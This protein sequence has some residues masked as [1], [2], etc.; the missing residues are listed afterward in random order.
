MPGLSGLRINQAGAGDGD[1]VPSVHSPCARLTLDQQAVL[2][3][4]VLRAHLSVP[5]LPPAHQQIPWVTPSCVQGS[6]QPLQAAAAR[7]SQLPWPLLQQQG[8]R[9]FPHWLGVNWVY[10]CSGMMVAAPQ[11]SEAEEKNLLCSLD[12]QQR[13]DSNFEWT[14]LLLVC[15]I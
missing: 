8:Q 13:R 7:W 9:F 6:P 5:R 12:H 14:S 1:A 4:A 15:L 3:P 10:L 2:I 11:L